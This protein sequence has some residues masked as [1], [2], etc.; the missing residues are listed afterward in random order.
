M[1]KKFNPPKTLEE[2]ERDSLILQYAAM[3]VSQLKIRELVG[4]DMSRISYILKHIPK[5]RYGKE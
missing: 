1:D 5:N 2:L 4:V 3:G